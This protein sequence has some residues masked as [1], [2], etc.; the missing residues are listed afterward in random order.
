[1]ETSFWKKKE[2]LKIDIV[3]NSRYKMKPTRLSCHFGV[4]T[5]EISTV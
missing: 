5:V 1:M 3:D 2:K 4:Q